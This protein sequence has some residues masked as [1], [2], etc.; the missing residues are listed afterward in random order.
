M[1]VGDAAPGFGRNRA[2]LA[3]V[4]SGVGIAAVTTALI[5]IPV[6]TL[7]TLFAALAIA[8]WAALS[9]C[10]ALGRRVPLPL[11]ALGVLAASLALTGSLGLTAVPLAI[12]LVRTLAEPQR[13]AWHGAALAVLTAL[14]LVGAALTPHGREDLRWLPVQLAMVGVMA[15]L[16]AA[17]RQVRR[18]ELAAARARE[19]ELEATARWQVLADRQALARELHDVLAHSLGG[20]VVQ[21]D[22]AEALLESGRADDAARTVGA[23]RALAATGLSEARDAVAQLREPPAEAPAR[24]A[25]LSAAVDPLVAEARGLGM[26]V[27]AQAGPDDAVSPVAAAAFHR[28]AQEALTNARKHAPGQPVDL[29]YAVCDGWAT[30]DVANALSFAPGALAESGGGN[31]LRGMRERFAQLPG[32]ELSAGTADGAFS[33]HARAR[34]E[35]CPE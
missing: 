20:L 31:G 4:R 17:R 27:R 16:G 15:A 10:A 22:A 24:S 13:P 23:A 1:T 6:G 30:L 11:A 35:G 21:L 18:S 12:V 7:P 9:V 28:A 8:V 26:E 34:A 14:A 33:L 32:G 5:V 29:A 25:S 19:V 2:A 3:L